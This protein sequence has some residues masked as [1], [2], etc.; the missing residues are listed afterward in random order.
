MKNLEKVRRVYARAQ[1]GY[2][3]S[4]EITELEKSAGPQRMKS[5]AS[6]EEVEFLKKYADLRVSSLARTMATIYSFTLLLAAAHNLQH[7]VQ[8]YFL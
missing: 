2:V 4:T 1:T 6:A 5:I 3:L 7:D 8:K